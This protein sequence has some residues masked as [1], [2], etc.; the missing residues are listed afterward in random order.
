MA[1]IACLNT[2]LLGLLIGIYAGEVPAI[3]YAIV[4]LHHYA[5]LGNVFFYIGLAIPTLLCW[6]LP[7]LHGRKP[8]TLGALVILLSLQ[9]PQGIAVGH[10]KA[11]YHAKYRALLLVCRGI[12]GLAMGFAN[13][14]FQT[15][16]LD[17]YGASLQSSNP[18]QEV[19][20]PNDVR[21]H[22][23]GMGVW[24]GVWSWCFIGSIAVGFFVGAGIIQHQS[25]TW[26]F[27]VAVMVT[28]FMILVNVVAPETR[29]NRHRSSMADA[30]AGE[31]RQ[32]KLEVQKGEVT[33]HLK[34]AGAQSVFEE[35]VSGLVLNLKM[36]KQPGFLILSIYT[37][38]VY[39]QFVLI[40][41]VSLP[42]PRTHIRR[43]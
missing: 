11:R 14:N 22:G 6:P 19:T 1:T 24:L 17:I 15:T 27:W 9:L 36:L 25:V 43:S 38:W 23:G 41:V 30:L 29:R 42:P 18:H 33:I 20:D 26:G 10:E 16:L 28:M 12:S 2:A 7:V 37:A 31:K 13:M 3:Q 35:V 4:D 40:V 34:S 39:G 8:Y 32:K 21:R 5:I